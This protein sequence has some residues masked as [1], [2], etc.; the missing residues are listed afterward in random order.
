[1]FLGGV[2]SLVLLAVQGALESVHATISCTSTLDCAAGET[3]VAADA[4][5][6]VQACVPST[7]CGGS[8]MG[9]CPNDA[10]VKLACLWRPD[11]DCIGGCAVL[12]G[13]KGI[14]KCVSLARCDAYY[15]G[16]ACSDGC[17]SNG[18][19]C[20]GKGSC[21]MMSMHAD[22]TPNFACTCENGYEGD[23]CDVATASNGTK[24]SSR[25]SFSFQD[26]EVGL[27]ATPSTSSGTGSTSN[28]SS[29]EA[30][31]ESSSVQG[32]HSPKKKSGSNATAVNNIGPVVSTSHR[33][34][35]A[36][37]LFILAMAAIFMLVMIMVVAYWRRRNAQNKEDELDNALVS[38]QGV[39]VVGLRDLAD[40]HTGYTPR[41]RNFKM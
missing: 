20:N 21:N 14:Y 36:R 30:P 2:S 40:G 6:V 35:R 15:G 10:S 31:D 16:T 23:R 12:H 5:T 27:E 7:V 19:R 17:T 34:I 37:V 33:G 41:S 13:E 1:M 4:D 11:Q 24:G 3:C 39:G 8:S 22:G 29:T 32:E 28:N 25:H 9:N 38:E 18:V 26:D